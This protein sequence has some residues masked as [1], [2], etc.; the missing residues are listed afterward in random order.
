VNTWFTSDTH[1]HHSNIIRYCSRPFPDVE[2]MNREMVERHNATVGDQDLVYHLGD[3]A[4]GGAEDI[5]RVKRALRGRMILI[6]GNHDRK[7][8]AFYREIGFEQVLKDLMNH[9][10]LLDGG[11]GWTYMSHRPVQ[12]GQGDVNLNGHVHERW[13]AR[14]VPTRP[15]VTRGYVSV[16]VGVDVWDFRPVSFRHLA[17]AAEHM[18]GE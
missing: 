18:R 15:G 9:R 2:T 1:Y 16:N 7:T 4:F 10:A 17:W 8:D 5:A 3:F 14:G 6:R 13:L 12:E 11:G